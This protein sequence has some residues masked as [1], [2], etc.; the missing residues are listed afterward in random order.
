MASIK[1][2]AQLSSCTHV[3]PSPK[4]P[5]V[6]TKVVSLVMSISENLAMKTNLLRAAAGAAAAAGGRRGVLNI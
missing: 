6:L 5:V 1:S 2:S 4:L 3:R